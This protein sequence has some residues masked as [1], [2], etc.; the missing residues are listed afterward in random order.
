MINSRK[1]IA[2]FGT[3]FSSRYRTGLCKAFITVAEELGVNIVFFNSLGKIGNKNAQY[4]DYEFDLIDY[5]DL[6]PFDGIVFDG[7]GYTV[8]G[9]ADKVIEKLRGASCPIISISTHVDGFYNIDFDDSAGTATLTEHFIDVHGFTRI[10]YMS[11]YLTHPDAQVRLKKFRE[12]MK[13]RG[14]PEDGVGVFEG[15][16][17]FGKGDEAAEFFLSRPEPPQ[18]VVCAND[19]MAIS[20]TTALK[21][22]GIGVPENIAV[23]GF[24]GTIEGREFLPHITSA[25][26]ER[27]DIARRALKL[28]LGFDEEGRAK[29]SLK[30]YP[31]AI[32]AQSCGCKNLNYQYEAENINRVYEINRGFSYNLYDA[33]S[34]MLKL[35][36]VN[37]IKKLEEVF[38]ETAI[39]FGDYS[40]FFMMMHVDRNGRPSYDSDYTSPTGK[41]TPVIWIDKNEEYIKPTEPFELSQMIPNVKS[42][43]P[44]FYYVTSVHCAER[45]FGYAAVEMSGK[46][47]FN[48]FYILW[49]LNLAITLETL[50]KNDRIN[51]LI[52]TLEDLSIRDGL[53]GMLNRRGFEELSREAIRSFDEDRTICTMVIDMDGLKHINDEYGHYEGDRAIQA[54]AN[55]ITKCCDAGEIAGRAG[56]DEFYIFAP[57]YSQKKLERFLERLEGQ[58]KNFNIVSNKP[59]DLEVSYGTNLTVATA[60]DRLEDLIKVSDTRMYEQK[61][62]KPNRRK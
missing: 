2:M 9:M 24:D 26:R 29:G 50:L 31:K 39:N 52:G 3:G 34:S 42:D 7:E 59:Y 37:S 40:T 49:L 15:D 1:N 33:Q 10:G 23:S 38:T 6:S 27:M 35:N 53:T 32:Y 18:A 5:I 58:V 19:Y 30:I 28:L 62:T 36:K 60:R 47:I 21:K 22:R 45:M 55:I 4:G 54:T 57:E 44:H 43:K 14:L 61:M 56:G 48:E 20:L 16:F 13:Q 11:G 8:E 12:V 51:K 25:T 46:D 41:F 17:W